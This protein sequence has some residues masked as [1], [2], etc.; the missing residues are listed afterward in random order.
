MT[1]CAPDNPKCERYEKKQARMKFFDPVAML[2]FRDAIP[3]IMQS[4]VLLR[5]DR[6]N[7]LLSDPLSTA[8]IPVRSNLR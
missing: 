6:I 3:I 2:C 1:Q 4:A 7:V 8:D 5:A